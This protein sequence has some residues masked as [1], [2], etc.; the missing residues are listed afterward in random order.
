MTVSAWVNSAAF[1][2]DD[3]AIVSKRNGSEVGYQLDTTIDRGPRTIGFKLTSS[4]GGRMFRYGATT[5]QANTWYHVAGVY[6]A[7]SASLHVY[8][9]GQLNDGVLDGTVTTSQQ[10]SPLNVNIGRR[11]SGG[12]LTIGRIDDVR[13]YSRA[14]TQAEIQA[15]M[16][17]PVGGGPPPDTLPPTTPTN[18]VA[19]PVSQSQINLNWTASTDASGVPLYR[20]ERCQ[21]AGC[22]NFA[23][24]GTT[25]TNS[26]NNTSL[27]PATTYRYQVRAQDG[28]PNPNLSGYSNIASAMTQGT[29]NTPPTATIS[30]P[31]TSTLWRVGDTINFAGSATDAEDPGGVVA[32]SGLSWT[33]VVQHCWQYDPTNC[34]SHTIQQLERRRERLVLRTRTTSI[35]R[36]SSSSSRRPTPAG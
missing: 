32:T 7:A 4:S 17:T 36:T 20:V 10:N 16:S 15:D 9:N 35:P 12:F 8:L 29:P 33:L 14:L 26:F 19:T 23:E 18:L 3:A 11:P 30:A 28:A 25:P 2:G 22:T 1:P 24:I 6:D 13:I 31:P 5:L 21:G 34:H 27:Q